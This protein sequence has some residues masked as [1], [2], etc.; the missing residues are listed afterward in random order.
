[1]SVWVIGTHKLGELN[2]RLGAAEQ[3]GAPEIIGIGQQ[4]DSREFLL[5]RL[6]RNYFL[7]ND[8]FPD[9]IIGGQSNEEEVD[10][11]LDIKRLSR[12][13]TMIVNIQDPKKD[14]Q[15]FDLIVSSDYESVV[16]NGPNVLNIKGM[17]HRMRNY[18]EVIVI[19]KVFLIGI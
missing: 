17:P 18:G 3:F 8:D 2:A 13:K 11:L 16:V 5:K 19:L 4:K 15:D 6:G 1:M 9:L 12:G 14:R 10:F 7:G